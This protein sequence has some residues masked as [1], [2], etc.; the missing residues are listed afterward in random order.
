MKLGTEQAT[1]S[2][3]TVDFT[4]IPAGTT[5]ITIS[6]VGWSGNGTGS[7]IIQ[8]GDA[9][10]IETTGYVGG[11][12]NV[13]GANQASRDAFPG[14]GFVFSTDS[15]AAEVHQGQ[16]I[17]TLEDSTNFTWSGFG[18]WW[19]PT[20]ATINWCIGNK[21]LTQE[22]TQIRFTTAAGDTFNAGAINIAYF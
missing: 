18:M 2:G 8:L 1:T 21:T 16:M 22:L 14:A 5:M 7:P 10:G 12:G 11:V 6:I 9:G 20:V 19:R 15:T 4:S 13:F 17:L 3:T